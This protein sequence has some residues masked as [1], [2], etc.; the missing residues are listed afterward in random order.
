ML[1]GILRSAN[2]GADPGKDEAMADRKTM[3]RQTLIGEKGIRPPSI[4]E[5]LT[6]NLLLVAEMPASLF[7]ATSRY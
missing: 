3:T 1:S 2:R 7:V 6:T 5:T 4:T